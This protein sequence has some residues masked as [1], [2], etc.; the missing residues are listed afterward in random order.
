MKLECTIARTLDGYF[1][2]MLWNNGIAQTDSGIIGD[3]AGLTMRKLN[4]LVRK[5][6]GFVEKSKQWVR[7]SQGQRNYVYLNT[8]NIYAEAV[9]F[10]EKLES[11]IVMKI[12]SNS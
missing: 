7:D 5:H 1:R 11:I 8:F 10:K 9:E 3:A 6:G 2:I 12:L 4:K